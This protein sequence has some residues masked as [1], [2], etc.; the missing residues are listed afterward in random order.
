MD[1]GEPEGGGEVMLDLTKDQLVFRFPDVHEDAV[2]RIDF[3]RTL[4]IPDDNREYHL[5]AG[6]G[7]FPMAH[8][9]DHASKLPGAWGEHGGALLPMHQAE[10]LWID[11]ECD[12]GGRSQG[13]PFA[14]KIAAG[15]VNAVT[16]THWTNELTRRPQDYLVLPEQPWLDGFCVSKDLVRQFVAMPLGQGYTAE[17]QLSGA[18]AHGGIQLIVYPMKRGCYEKLIKKESRTAPETALYCL[19]EAAADGA[20][21]GLA[22]G[23]LMRQQLYEDDY[24]YDAWDRTQSSRCFV[25]I[26]NSRQWNAATGKPMPTKPPSTTEYAKAGLPWF[27][28]YDDEAKPLAGSKTLAGLDSVAAKGVKLGQNPLPGKEAVMPGKVIAL[29][30]KSQIGDGK[31]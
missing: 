4:R 10:A 18:A 28:Y 21:M 17:E 22:P 12:A 7:R 26:L 23:G 5:P 3:Q 13:Y 1:V 29:G 11:F 19:Q 27:D 2:C 20:A 24:G 31:W 25:H 14:V 16:G 30:S 8:V 9:K 15:K 6:L